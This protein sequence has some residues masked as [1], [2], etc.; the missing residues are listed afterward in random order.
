M[1]IMRL[2]HVTLDE[3]ETPRILTSATETKCK[4]ELNRGEVLF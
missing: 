4:I 2:S 1:I 3:G